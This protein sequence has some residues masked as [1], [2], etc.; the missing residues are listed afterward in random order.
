ME[1]GLRYLGY[2]EVKFQGYS[3]SEYAN[4]VVDKKSTLKC[5]F[6]LGSTIVS[7]FSK[8]QTSMALSL[9][10]TEYTIDSTTSCEAM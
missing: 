6:S 7:W 8:K 2:G 9:A 4:N 5:C 1:Y 10:E 3:N